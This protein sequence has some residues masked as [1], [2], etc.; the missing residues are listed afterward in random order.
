M[1][2]LESPEELILW[3]KSQNQDLEI[4]FVPTM[5]ALHAGHESLIETARKHTDLV[6]VS[7]F[8][9]PTQFNQTSDYEKYPITTRADLAICEKHRVDAVFLPKFKDMLYPDQYHFKMTEDSLSKILCGA[10]RPGH[11]DGV[12]S[13]VMKLFLL[14]RPTHAFF[15]EKDFQQLTLIQGMV[16]AY[17]LPIEIVPCPTLREPSGLAMSSRNVRLTEQDRLELAPKIYETLKSATTAANATETL[18]TLGFRVE[19]CEDHAFFGKRRRLIAAW[20][21]SGA[22]EVRL[23][24]NIS[25]GEAP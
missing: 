24:D 20:L 13:I 6:V 12:L 25:L 23:I 17:F 1:R 14:V 2:I 21:G 22:N 18:S 4:G 8:V 3:R 11:F 7:I 15:G 16:Q 19:Y 9:N 5:G 10:H